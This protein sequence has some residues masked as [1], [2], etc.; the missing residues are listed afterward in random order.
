M[1]DISM[2]RIVKTKRHVSNGFDQYEPMICIDAW[3][4]NALNCFFQGVD[5]FEELKSIIVKH[6][7]TV[8]KG[9][10][11]ECGQRIDYLIGLIQKDLEGE[12]F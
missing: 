8:G 12:Q 9:A 4:Q 1:I 6:T 11:L 3:R 2:R 5:N 10:G 7:L